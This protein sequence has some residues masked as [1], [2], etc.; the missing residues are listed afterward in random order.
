MK[1]FRAERIRFQSELAAIK[2]VRVIP[3]QANFV[4]VELET[5][6]DPKDLLKKLLIK[7]FIIRQT[8]YVEYWIFFHILVYNR[9]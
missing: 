6:I 4:M 5:G 3:S 7:A 2:G 1:L 9:F 8:N